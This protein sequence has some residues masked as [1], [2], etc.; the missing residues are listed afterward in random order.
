MNPAVPLVL[1]SPHSG[2][3]FPAD[4]DASAHVAISA[5]AEAASGQEP[6][7]DREGEQDD[8]RVEEDSNEA[9]GNA[10]LLEMARYR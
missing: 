3:D 6:D 7:D 4:F 9:E 10:R 5:F 8:H 2:H 1:D